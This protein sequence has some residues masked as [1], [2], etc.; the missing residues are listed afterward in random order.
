MFMNKNE[1]RNVSE[2]RQS[3]STALKGQIFKYLQRKKI[4]L[5]EFLKIPHNGRLTIFEMESEYFI[6]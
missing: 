6:T 3:L 4:L 2:S 5:Y 1:Y